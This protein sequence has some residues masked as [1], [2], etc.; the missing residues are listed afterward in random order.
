M[1]RFKT[2]LDLFRRS[3]SVIRQNKSLLLFPVIVSAFIFI[4]VLFFISPFVLSNTGHALTDPLHWK[5]LADRI[6][7]LAENKDMV[8]GAAGFAWFAAIYLVS[9]F[10]ATFLM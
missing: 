8:S 3:W 2:S 9:I 1:G 5:V 10:M 7:I 6:K 4:I